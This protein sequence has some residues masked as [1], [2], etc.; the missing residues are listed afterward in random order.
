MQ[1]PLTPAPHIRPLNS[2]PA[3][4]RNVVLALVPGLAVYIWSFGWGIAVNVAVAVAVATGTEAVFMRLRRRDFRPALHDGSAIVTGV[5]LALALPPLLPWW[6]PAL[7]A[8]SAIV[9]GKQLYGG[10]GANLFNPA[11]VGYVIVLISFPAEM[12]QWVAPLGTGLTTGDL[13]LADHLVYSLAGTLPDGFSID[14]VT[15]ATPLDVIKLGLD[16]MRTIEEIRVGP[17]FSGFAG[18][19]WQATNIAIALGGI[20]LLYRGIIRWQIPT[21][22]LVG[23]LIPATL[24][25]L[26]DTSR[27]PSPAF[28]LLGG[29][30]LLGAFFIATDPVTA[31]GTDRGRLIYGAGIG[32]LTY[33]I[34]TWGGYPDGF[35]FAVLLMNASVP[36]IDRYTQPRIYGHD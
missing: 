35:A 19:G 12:I 3:L 15:Q 27:F 28:H 13:G 18:A 16:N 21:A 20:Y 32:A 31:A 17:L 36:I 14:A 29:A 25:F 30:T 33:A 7:A 2:V 8:I 5:L 9:L 34:R 6:V 11:M 24:L 10:L 22:V 1:F 23:M 26:A 4:M